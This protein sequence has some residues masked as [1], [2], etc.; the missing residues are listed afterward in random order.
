[1]VGLRRDRRCTEPRELTVTAARALSGDTIAATDSTGANVE[2]RLSDIGVPQG[3][4]PYAPASRVLLA[5]VVDGKTLRVV[6]TGEPSA[7]RVFGRVFAGELDVNRELVRRGAAWVCWEYAAD[8]SLL[9][10]ENGA[11]RWRRGVWPTTWHIQARVS[12]RER[13]PTAFRVP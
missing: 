4:Q 8:T 1:M 7:G 2:V 9:Q 13:P 11:Y 12:C 5:A 3:S 10:D 6:V